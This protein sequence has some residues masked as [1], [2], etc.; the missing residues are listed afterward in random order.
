MTTTTQNEPADLMTLVD[1]FRKNADQIVHL[2]VV[3]SQALCG[4]HTCEDCYRK[5]KEE[6]ERIHLFVDLVEKLAAEISDIAEAIE[7]ADFDSPQPA[8][9]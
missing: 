1:Q 2:A 4:L 8:T 3:T 9:A 7:V 5:D 6:H